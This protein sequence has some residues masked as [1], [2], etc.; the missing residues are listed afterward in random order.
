ML[1]DEL[2]EDGSKE[3]D[4]EPLLS[5]TAPDS[6]KWVA[7]FPTDVSFICLQTIQIVASS[8]MP[9]NE[10]LLPK[11]V[12]KRFKIPNVHQD[13]PKRSNQQTPII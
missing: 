3:K 8:C 12:G 4:L 11:D 7:T 9:H 6:H 10:T 5:L 2:I 13:L 1:K